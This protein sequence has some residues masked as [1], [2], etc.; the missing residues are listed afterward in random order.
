MRQLFRAAAFVTIFNRTFYRIR[1]SSLGSTTI[2]EN[3]QGETFVSSLT[4]SLDSIM[5]LSRSVFSFL[6]S[7]SLAAIA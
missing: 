2:Y 6:R 5:S 1:T 3:T 7:V 4:F